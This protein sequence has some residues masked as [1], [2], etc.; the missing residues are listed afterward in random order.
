[1]KKV[2]LYIMVILPSIALMLS[3]SGCSEVKE[4][5]ASTV[6]LTISIDYGPVQGKEG[7]DE[8]YELDMPAGSSLWD[9]TN[10]V[11]EVEATYY[12][13]Y[14]DYLIDSINGVESNV[15][16]AGYWWMWYHVNDGEEIGAAGAK[17]YKLNQGDRIL[18]RYEI[19]K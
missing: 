17:G 13:Q 19:P 15:T 14:E 5:P 7:I 2:I 9:A 6:E 11:A 1:M 12:K 3:T 18:W 16:V 10:K 8:S 4:S